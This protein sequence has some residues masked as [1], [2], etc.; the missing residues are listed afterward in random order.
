[1]IGWCLYVWAKSFLV[2]KIEDNEKLLCY[3]R[4]ELADVYL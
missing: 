1:M 3:G 4:E 2:F